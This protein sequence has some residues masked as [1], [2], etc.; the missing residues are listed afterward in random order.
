M[1][2]K[3]TMRLR[4]SSPQREAQ[5]GGSGTQR[6]DGRLPEQCIVVMAL[7]QSVIRN[8]WCDVVHVMQANAAVNHCSTR[9]S[10][11]CE[12]PRSAASR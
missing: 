10:L 7:L 2:R 9:E 3:R 12:L 6:H 8:S 1:S 5:R 4:S 11:R